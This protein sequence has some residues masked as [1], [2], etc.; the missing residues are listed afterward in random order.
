MLVCN[1]Q[2]LVFHCIFDLVWTGGVSAVSSL[3]YLVLCR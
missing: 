3:M 2:I 1:I